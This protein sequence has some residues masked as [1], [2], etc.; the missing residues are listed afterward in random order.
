MD[1]IIKNIN[2]TALTPYPTDPLPY[3]VVFDVPVN[4]H[5]TRPVHHA[6]VPLPG[7]QVD[8]AIELCC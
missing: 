7:M 8:S 4:Q 5:L 2:I 3:P 6:D 1:G